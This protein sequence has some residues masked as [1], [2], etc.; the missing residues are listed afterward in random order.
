MGSPYRYFMSNIDTYRLQKMITYHCSC[1]FYVD[2]N[3]FFT[4]VFIA[5][6]HKY[7]ILKLTLYQIYY[8]FQSRLCFFLMIQA[9][10]SLYC[11]T[12]KE[13]HSNYGTH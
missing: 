1:A 8:Y 9:I 2:S 4:C 12:Y 7:F 11:I 10:F 6:Q 5:L 3:L 13:A